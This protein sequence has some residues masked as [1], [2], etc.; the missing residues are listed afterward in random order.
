ME[1]RFD[2]RDEFSVAASLFPRE[3]AD[4]SLTVEATTLADLF[5]TYAIGRCHLLKMDCEGAE[6]EILHHCPDDVFAATDR[7]VLEVHDWVRDY[8]TV[9]D[10]ARMLRGKGYQ[11]RNHKNEILTCTR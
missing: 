5:T 11:V 1:I 8:G 9:Q 3:H 4:G 10:L 6:F 7:I 2:R